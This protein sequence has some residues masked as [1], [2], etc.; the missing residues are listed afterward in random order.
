MT[1]ARK[2]VTLIAC[3][4]LSACGGGGGDSG[5][6]GFA[7]M[8]MPGTPGTSTGAPDDGTTTPP[9][10]PIDAALDSGDPGGLRPEDRATLLERA[11]R[12]AIELRARPQQV[13]ADIYNTKG[14]VPNLALDIGKN[15]AALTPASLT[16]AIPF[17]VADD[18]SG[19]AAIAELGDGRA[20]AY[21]ADVLGWMAGTTKE[22]Q[23]LPLFTRA[24]TWV[25]TGQAEGTLPATLK[26]SQAGYNAGAIKNFATRLQRKTQEIACDIASPTN[27]CWR[28]ADLLVFGASVADNPA[29]GELVRSYVKAGKAVIYM[30]S[31]WWT[32]PGGTRLL[33]SLGMDLAADPGNFFAPASGYSVSAGRTAVDALARG[34]QLGSLVHTLEWLARDT[35]TQD[36]AVD[37][38]PIV[39]I[40]AARRDLSSTE[41][42][43]RPLFKTENTELQRLLVLWADEWRRDIAYGKINR[44]SDAAN[45]LRAYASDSWQAFGRTATTTQP[46]GQGDY[47]PAGA[48]KLATSTDDETIEL[49]LP[50]GSGKTAIGRG[51]IPAKAVALE[52][53]EAPVGVNLG[54]QTSHIRTY[55]NPLT[56]AGNYI[57]PRQAPSWTVPLQRDAVNDFVTP[58]GGPLFLSYSGA[59]AGQKVKLRV[60]GTVRYAHFDFSQGT[61]AQA[62]LDAAM[63]ALQRQDYGWSTFKF[64]GGE[65]QQTIAVALK[66]FKSGMPSGT[67]RTPQDLVTRRIEGI[68]MDTNHMSNGYNDMKMPSTVSTLC[69]SFAWACDDAVH[70]APGVQHFVS[71]LP[72]CG[73]GCS[74]HP[75]DSD[76]WAMDIG[77]GWPHELG[78]N[79]VQPWMHIVIDDKGCST[80]CDN[81]TL[82]SAHMLRR[83]A[84][85]GEDDSGTRTAH[86]ALY[87]MIQDNRA[88]ALSGEPQRADMQARLWGGPEQSPMLAMYFQLAFLYTQARHSEAQPTAASTIEFLTLLSKGGRLVAKKWSTNTAGNYGMSGYASNDISNHEL[89]YVLSSKIIGQDLRNVFAMYGVPLTQP[90][91]ASVAALTLPMAPQRFYALGANKANQLSTGQWLSVQGQ[92]PAYPF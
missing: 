63:A 56:D 88:L 86:A 24:F 89:L 49:T 35:Y 60:K 45:F 15:S 51:A 64:R 79:T 70:N 74:G 21:G 37:N 28:D 85:L 4:V 90:A 32:A 6:G 38:Q 52:I 50:Q 17:I 73:S 36:F 91:L 71:W 23:H 54:V 67:L 81:N 25:M 9:A 80:E 42:A 84:V 72:R 58:F 34:D 18:G 78:H 76:N 14:Q 46:G 2:L 11:T 26:F 20:L 65:L 12:K 19:I 68:L 55:G 27:T 83:Y 61:P 5:G 53:A 44:T 59:T 87:R 66:S 1:H 40:D 47:M 82:S 62:E 29:L 30:H 33:S 41:L 75:I 7:G 57:R 8:G 13:L 43:G 39:G 48:Q 10:S 16:Q 31:S 69:T 92:T 3:L 77:W 22:Q